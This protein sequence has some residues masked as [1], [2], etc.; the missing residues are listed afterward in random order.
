MSRR[1]QLLHLN[2]HTIHEK[3]TYRV[4]D[5]EK[6]LIFHT[7][8][9]N[10]A[11]SRKAL[12]EKLKFR[13]ITVSIIIRE[14]LEDDLIHETSITDTSKKGRKERDLS[15]NYARFTAISIGVVSREISGTLVDLGGSILETKS[16]FMPESSDNTA[17][18]ST[19]NEIL[20]FLRKKIPR[21]SEFTGIS[22]SLPGTVNTREKRWVSSSRWPHLKNLSLDR[23]DLRPAVPVILHRFLDP[24][25]KFLLSTGKTGETGNAILFHWGYGIGSAAAANGTILTSSLGRFGEVGHWNID[26]ESLEECRCGS[27]GCLET[28]AALWAIL[29]EIKKKYPEAPEDESEFSD[30]FMENN[31]E[32]LPVIQ[33]ALETTAISLANL[34]KIFYPDKIFLKGPF[35]KSKTLLENL[36][37][38][39][40]REIPEYNS[41]KNLFEVIPDAEGSV[42][43]SIYPLF[44]NALRPLMRTRGNV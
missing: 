2:I 30:F 11:R 1:N 31:L 18:L 21:T 26:P 13:P 39:F 17:L 37:T 27:R 42:E 29:P 7:L 43:G 19:I 5:K 14:L 44:R 16:V 38:I 4:K 3:G 12:A 34:C 28:T 40:Y 15:L 25:L 9:L 8:W 20:I 10:E 32:N 36:K 33:K 22:L 24:E 35:F 6:A 23:L 41:G